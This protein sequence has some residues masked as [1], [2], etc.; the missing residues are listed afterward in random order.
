M[1]KPKAKPK[2]PQTGGQYQRNE[3]GDLQPVKAQA[4]KPPKQTADKAAEE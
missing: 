3:R 1:S 4:G 2:L